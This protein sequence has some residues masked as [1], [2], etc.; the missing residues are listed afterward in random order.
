MPGID[1]YLYY[2]ME[3][4]CFAADHLV[5]VAGDLLK[6]IEYPQVRAVVYRAKVNFFA[7]ARVLEKIVKEGIV[8]AN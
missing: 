1:K 5:G 7:T 8:D 3:D 4:L 6:K 2:R